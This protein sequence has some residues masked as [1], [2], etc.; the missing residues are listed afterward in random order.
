MRSFDLIEHN[1]YLVELV[2][3]YSNLSPRPWS[4]MRR[5][6]I[7]CRSVAFQVKWVPME[8]DALSDVAKVQVLA[9][10]ISSSCDL[11]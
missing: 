6:Q 5:L 8:I 4:G 3:A 10:F 7:K 9:R 11:P 1:F 2:Q